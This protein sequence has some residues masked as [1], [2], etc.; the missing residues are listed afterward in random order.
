MSKDTDTD[1]GLE[2]PKSSSKILPKMKDN[3]TK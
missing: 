2:E 3:Q 1:A